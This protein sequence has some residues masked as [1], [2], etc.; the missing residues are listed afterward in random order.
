MARR[1]APL[2][3]ELNV[4]SP[5]P[6][7]AVLADRH[8]VL[9]EGIRDLLESVFA[10]VYLVA[11]ARSLREGARRLSPA[12]IV[13]DLS[14][15]GLG[16]QKLVRKLGKRSP[17]SRIIVLSVHDEP[18]VA[19]RAL[20]AGAN[21]VVLKRCVGRDFMLAIDAVLTGQCYVSPELLAEPIST[22]GNSQT[23]VESLNPTERHSART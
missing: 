11:D 14:L 1:P 9:A 15:S 16:F 19:Q 21:G 6:S 4:G 10:T 13:L 8:T 20:E 18:V 23:N 22:S 12:L 3:R 5:N 2:E 17:G 7:C